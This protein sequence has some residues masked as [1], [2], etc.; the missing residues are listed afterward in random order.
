MKQKVSSTGGVVEALSR[1]IRD[2]LGA[3]QFHRPIRGGI[4]GY[5][6]TSHDTTGFSP[7]SQICTNGT[8]SRKHARCCKHEGLGKVVQSIEIKTAE[9]RLVFSGMLIFALGNDFFRFLP[10]VSGNWFRLGHSSIIQ[11]RDYIVKHDGDW[12][13]SQN[14]YPH[15]YSRAEW[16]QRVELYGTSHENTP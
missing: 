15:E 12:Y 5:W 9:L 13:H 2:L 1:R 6:A 14:G 3:R 4:I 7:I 10:N 16:R 8:R 11:P